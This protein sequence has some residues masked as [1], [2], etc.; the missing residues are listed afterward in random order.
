MT[1][2]ASVDSELTLLYRRMTGPGGQPEWQRG[3]IRTFSERRSPSTAR[4]FSHVAQD[5][6]LVTRLDGFTTADVKALIDRGVAP[7]TAG[8]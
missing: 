7:A 8:R 3:R 6:F 4:R 1:A 2:I 5:I